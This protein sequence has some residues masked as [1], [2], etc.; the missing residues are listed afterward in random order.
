MTDAPTCKHFDFFAQVNVA[1][2]EDSGRFMAEIEIHCT[3]CGE[4]FQFLGLEP[5]LN[6]N[7]AA[8]SIDGLQANVAIAPNSQVMSPLQKMTAGIAAKPVRYTL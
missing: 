4:K 1:R 2:L 3:E 7:G 5:G 8:V 6:L